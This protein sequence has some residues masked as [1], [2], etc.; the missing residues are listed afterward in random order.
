MA[1]KS[2][3]IK[4]I[5]VHKNFKKQNVLNGVS[6]TMNA[7]EIYGMVGLNGIGKTTIIKII[8]GLL[9]QDKGEVKLFGKDNNSMEVKRNITYLPEKFAPSP[10]LK[11]EEFLSIACG[12]Y[13]KKYDKKEAETVCLE[14]G[15]NP[16]ELPKKVSKYSKGMGQKLGLVSVFMSHS[17]LL[18]LDEPMSGLD[19]SARIFLKKKLKKYR[20]AGNSIFFTSHILSDVE[21]ICDKIGIIHH[22]SLHYEGSVNKFIKTYDTSNLEQAFLRAI[23]LKVFL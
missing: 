16:E 11:G 4:V 9:S 7:G 13:G 19:P 10:F 22:G 23:E 14:L 2:Q 18:I 17:P 1:I 21:E 20:E 3:I 6:F 15:F 12:Y 8:L 5:D